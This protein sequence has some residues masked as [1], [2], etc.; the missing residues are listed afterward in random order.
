MTTF[1]GFPSDT[2]ARAEL[3]HQFTAAVARSGGYR[4]E[5]GV[6]RDGYILIAAAIQGSETSVNLDLSAL[7]PIA[8]GVGT[9]NKRHLTSMT[10]F[11]WNLSRELANAGCLRKLASTIAD[12][13]GISLANHG[14]G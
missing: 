3:F 6:L 13:Y 10:I 8:Q 2:A 7:H 12:E 5:S 9:R 1:T 14:I 11:L 4:P